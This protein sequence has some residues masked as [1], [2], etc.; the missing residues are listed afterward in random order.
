MFESS[1]ANKNFLNHFKL[2]NF[3]LSQFEYSILKVLK[4][5]CDTFA[6]SNQFHHPNYLLNKVFC[7]HK[8]MKISCNN[9]DC[10]HCNF[11]IWILNHLKLSFHQILKLHISLDMRV[12]NLSL[13]YIQVNQRVQG[14]IFLR[15]LSFKNLIISSK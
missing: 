14:K 4:F 1:E 15:N 6:S 7:L 5:C 2:P 13:Q 10:H 12:Q 8:D 11:L 3:I 9:L